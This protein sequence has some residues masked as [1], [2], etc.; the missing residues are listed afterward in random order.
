MKKVS[1]KKRL[2]KQTKIRE[3]RNLQK[4]MMMIQCQISLIKNLN[5][6]PNINLKVNGKMKQLN[7][8]KK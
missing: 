6:N 5:N 2:N 8:M 7:Q 4:K 3:K 1:N